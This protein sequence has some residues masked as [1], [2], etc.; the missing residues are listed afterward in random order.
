MRTRTETQDLVV[1]GDDAGYTVSWC[2]ADHDRIRGG[3]VVG[4]TRAD[5]TRLAASIAKYTDGLGLAGVDFGDPSGHIGCTCY[6]DTVWET[7]A[8]ASLDDAL[9]ARRRDRRSRKRVLRDSS[10]RFL[11]NRLLVVEDLPKVLAHHA[12]GPGLERLVRDGGDHGIAVLALAE[13]AP[14]SKVT[15]ALADR[16]AVHLDPQAP[17]GLTAIGGYV[18]DFQPGRPHRLDGQHRWRPFTRN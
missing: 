5:R 11:W 12:A 18:D 13:A 4:G 15:S 14:V 1:G 10:G 9:A 16:N 7:D 6:G 3:L 17:V 2:L 8:V